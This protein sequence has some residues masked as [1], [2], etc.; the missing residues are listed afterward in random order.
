MRETLTE[1]G[2]TVGYDNI[3]CTDTFN[4]NGLCDVVFALTTKGD[5]HGTAL[6]RDLFDFNSNGPSVFDG[7]IEGGTFA[8]ANATG[9]VHLTSLPDGDTQQTF[10]I[11]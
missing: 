6:V 9:Y 7:D 8:Y 5:I 4:N 3:I 11:N 10:L 1:N 2:A